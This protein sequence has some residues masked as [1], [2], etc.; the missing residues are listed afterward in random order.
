VNQ[1]WIHKLALRKQ[2]LAGLFVPLI[3]V[4]SSGASGTGSPP[5]ATATPGAAAQAGA[6]SDASQDAAASAQD[7]PGVAGPRVY[8]VINLGA[9]VD[10]GGYLNQ[11]GQVAAYGPARNSFFD[12]DRLHDVGSLGGGYTV[13]SGLNNRG[14]VVGE[15]EDGNEPH[16]NILAFSWTVAGG[17]RA[18]PFPGMSGSFANAINDR[19]Q[20]AGQIPAPGISGRA[21]RWEPDGRIVNLGP[22]PLSLSDAR[23]INNRAEA[24]GFADVADG[25]IRAIKWSASGS[26]TDLGTLGGTSDAST[27]FVNQRGDAAGM[28]GN[29][30]FF[31]SARSGIVATGAQGH[32]G[33]GQV[34]G[35]DEHGEVGGNTEVPGGTGAYLWSRSRGLVLLPGGAAAGTFAWGMNNRRQLVGSIGASSDERAV[36]W[37]G[38]TAPVDLNTRL[39]RPP[40]GL[41]L[42]SGRTINDRGDIVAISNAG[43][44]LLRPGTRGTD[45]PVLGPIAGLPD[46]ANVGDDLQLTLGFVDNSR[47]QTHTVAVSWDD[48]CTSPLPMLQ[49]AGGVGEVKFQHRFCASGFYV[50]S[51]RVTDSAGR[52]TEMSKQVNVNDP[53]TTTLNGK[54]TLAPTAAG[55]GPRT[56][57]LH[58]ALWVPLVNNPAAASSGSKA[59]T[60]MV[61][62]SGPFQFRGEQLGAPARSGQQ[63]RLEG[64]GR[65]NG[66]P[67]YRFLIEAS[68]DRVRVHVAHTD[69]NGAEVVDYDNLAPAIAVTQGAAGRAA[70]TAD[71]TR[72]A[73]GWVKLS[74]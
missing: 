9:D 21:V 64:T 61:R 10:W 32:E 68:R 46:T 1:S 62:L 60:P 44:V 74:N 11:K 66:R 53:A 22:L 45:A 15:S 34:V 48:G 16:S 72:V 17:M 49:E 27:S 69:G 2:T 41:V 25:S 8:S 28:S 38:L 33:V 6:T 14:V 57:P 23:A 50:V 58:F 37:D 29:D 7:T 19:N 31:W 39:H 5:A 67:G 35:L 40:A 63:V 54:G 52:T 3:I 73:D 51:V 65:L 24:G 59:G 71:A 43:L 42:S 26:P 18:L 20:I 36:R 56:R 13:V 12:G 55:G 70:G 4:A 30:V 47:T